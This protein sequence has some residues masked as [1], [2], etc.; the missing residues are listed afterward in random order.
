MYLREA[1]TGVKREG[2][3]ASIEMEVDSS[4]MG[5]SK[6]AIGNTVI[7]NNLWTA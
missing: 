3:T 1:T 7:S 5:N 4:T 2:G 6:A